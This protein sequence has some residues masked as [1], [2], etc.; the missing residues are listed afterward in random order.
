YKPFPERN[1]TMVDKVNGFF[2]PGEHLTK[3]MQFFELRTSVDIRVKAD[4]STSSQAA[5]DKLVEVISLN[6]QPVISGKPVL[7]AEE[8][9]YVFK[10]GIEHYGA[11]DGDETL[12]ESL[13]AHAGA[14]GFEAENTTVT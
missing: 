5:L 13:V 7:D 12:V 8:S 4:G 11:W 14:H 3:N 9:E 10:F 2:A 6:G 1:T